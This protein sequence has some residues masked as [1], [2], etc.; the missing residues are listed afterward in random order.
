MVT[1]ITAQELAENPDIPDCC[2]VGAEVDMRCPYEGKTATEHCAVGE[3]CVS[4][5]A[6][7]AAEQSGEDHPNRC[8]QC[9]KELYS[10]KYQDGD[11]IDCCK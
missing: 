7:C 2:I 9:S 6:S 10:M 8:C 3:H 4:H 11:T 1:P 5:T